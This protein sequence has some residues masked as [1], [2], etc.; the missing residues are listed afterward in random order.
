MSK[1]AMDEIKIDYLP[2]D[3]YGPNNLPKSG[4][5]NHVP[6]LV[7]ARIEGIWVGAIHFTWTPKASVSERQRTHTDKLIDI[8]QEQEVVMAGDFNIPRGNENYKKLRARYVDNVPAQ[9]ETTIDP[10]LH[11]ANK[12]VPGTLKL[13]VDYVW[14]TPEY[15]VE[16]VRVVSGVSD[17]CAIVCEI[18]SQITNSPILK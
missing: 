5:D 15:V 9:I 12:N 8:L 14:S 1:L 6:C 11:Y 2:M 7:R 18:N 17:H 3:G 4:L 13:V 16:N 10:I